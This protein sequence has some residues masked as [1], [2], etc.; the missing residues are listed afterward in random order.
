MSGGRDLPAD[1]FVQSGLDVDELW[2]RF[3][4][5]EA[6]HHSLSIATPMSSHDLDRVVHLLRPSPNDQVLDLA[7]GQGELLVR[8]RRR[9]AIH[10]VGVDLSPWMIAAA[11]DRDND[12]EWVLA[13]AKRLLSTRDADDSLVEDP[14]GGVVAD[15]RW[16]TVCCLGASWIWYGLR[17]T[18]RTVAE[19]VSPGGMVAVGDMHVRPGVDP[20]LILE[21]HG[22]VDS[23]ADIDGWFTDNGL[24]VLDQVSTSDES[25]LAYHDRVDGAASSWGE[26]GTAGRWRAEAQAWRADADRDRDVLTWSVWV[27][28]KRTD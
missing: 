22:R 27:A 7:C 19:L 23:L 8:M 3:E 12:L 20:Q 11:A 10:G 28:R 17:G 14:A 15:H 2:E 5:F 18:I 4:I 24:E 16:D 21:S 1:V 9:A 26:S 25:W 13:E 6:L